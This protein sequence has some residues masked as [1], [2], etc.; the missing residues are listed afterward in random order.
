MAQ[1]WNTGPAH[2]FVGIGTSVSQNVTTVNGWGNNNDITDTSS[3]LLSS[4]SNRN[5]NPVYLGTTEQGLKIEERFTFDEAYTDVR[6]SKLPSD[7]IYEGKVYVIDGIFNFYN[8]DV[9]RRLVRMPI[10]QAAGAVNNQG[11][12]EQAHLTGTM[13]VLEKAAYP[14]IIWT[15]YGGGNVTHPGMSQ[16]TPARK[17]RRA[18]LHPVSWIASTKSQKKFI[19]WVVIPEYDEATNSF[20]YWDEIDPST[21]RFTQ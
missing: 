4:Q 11:K 12:R 17:Y 16:I 14:L 3:Q 5:D 19:N 18:I 20:L 2:V 21:L 1:F 13:M 10:P 15:P 7:L 9:W 8:E 6:G